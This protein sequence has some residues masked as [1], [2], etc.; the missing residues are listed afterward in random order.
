MRS[1]ENN[2]FEKCQLKAGLLINLKK[3]NPT[4]NNE[5][6]TYCSSHFAMPTGKLIVCV[7]L[8]FI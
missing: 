7:L 5:I 6:F 1:V 4:K 3:C 8:T 2:S